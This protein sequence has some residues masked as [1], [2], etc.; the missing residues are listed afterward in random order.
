MGALYFVVAFIILFLISPKDDGGVKEGI[1]TYGAL[2]AYVRTQDYLELKKRVEATER[3]RDLNRKGWEVE[4]ADNLSLHAEIEKLEAKLEKIRD[5]SD[6]AIDWKQ[7][8]ETAES[9]LVD[10]ER[11]SLKLGAEIV[12]LQNALKAKGEECE[13]LK[14]DLEKTE[15]LLSNANMERRALRATEE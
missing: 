6:K 9:A 1:Q 10:E 14:S 2:G 13:R 8:A 15:A 3:E 5:W 11:Q 4:E 12:R 7:R